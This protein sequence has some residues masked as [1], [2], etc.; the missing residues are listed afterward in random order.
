MT[1][2][3]PEA[4]AAMLAPLDMP[5]GVRLWIFHMTSPA[6]G[7]KTWAAKIGDQTFFAFGKT[8]AAA[9]VEAAERFNDGLENGEYPSGKIPKIGRR[10]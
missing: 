2:V 5:S 7:G 8:A 1:M 9:V 10:R 3:D 6:E 4:L